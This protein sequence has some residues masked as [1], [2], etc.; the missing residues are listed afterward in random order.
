LIFAIADEP[1]T[2]M[3]ESNLP[4][5]YG[6]ARL[7]AQGQNPDYAAFVGTRLDPVMPGLV[8]GFRASTSLFCNQDVDGRDKHG[9]D[10]VSA[11]DNTLSQRS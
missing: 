11:G 2:D 5:P 8:P 3:F 10:A 4:R 7:R 6:V 1:C 9:H